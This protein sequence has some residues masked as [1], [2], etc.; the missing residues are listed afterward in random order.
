[1]ILDFGFAICD[2]RFAWDLGAWKTR[3]KEIG[4][5]LTTDEHGSAG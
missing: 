2:L 1:L 4:G 5:N 3:L